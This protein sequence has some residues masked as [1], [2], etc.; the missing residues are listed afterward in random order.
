MKKIA[1]KIG[2][3]GREF[4]IS[5]DYRPIIDANPFYI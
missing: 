4:P 2:V 3:T 1:V 5:Q